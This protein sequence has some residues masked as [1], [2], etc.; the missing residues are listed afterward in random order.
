MRNDR[1]HWKTARLE[2]WPVVPT[3]FGAAA[4]SIKA[5]AIL[6][7]PVGGAF[8]LVNR[9]AGVSLPTGPT[10]LNR[11]RLHCPKLVSPG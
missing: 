4:L 10:R 7:I 9:S 5:V 1:S 8:S 3:H 6:V 11:T 2:I